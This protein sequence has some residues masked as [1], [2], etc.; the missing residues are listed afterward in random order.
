MSEGGYW[1]LFK[2][3]NLWDT[4][5]E[6]KE[7][8]TLTLQFPF[9]CHLQPWRFHGHKRFAS[10]GMGKEPSI[11]INLSLLQWKEGISFNLHFN[12]QSTSE[13]FGSPQICKYRSFRLYYQGRLFPRLLIVTLLVTPILESGLGCNLPH[14]VGNTNHRRSLKKA[15]KLLPLPSREP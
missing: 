9:L 11:Y 12:V 5:W 2:N 13:T 4:A 3:W 1:Y 6:G 10:L 15:C 14:P 8:R 7:S